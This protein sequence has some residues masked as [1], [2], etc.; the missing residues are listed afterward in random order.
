MHGPGKQIFPAREGLML[1]RSALKAKDMWAR[2]KT[3]GCTVTFMNMILILTDGRKRPVFLRHTDLSALPSGNKA[4][5]G[6]AGNFWE[7]DPAIDFWTNKSDTAVTMDEATTGF[8]IGNKAYLVANDSSLWEY[9]PA[10][11]LPIKWEQKADFNGHFGS[12][13]FSI[14]TKGY[15]GVHNF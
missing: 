5:L 11:V 13:S 12:V 4:Y 6:S 7:Y 10:G 2:V 9:T 1:L 14:G 3:Q 15:I 8:G